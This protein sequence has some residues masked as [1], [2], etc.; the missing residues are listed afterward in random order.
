MGCRCRG[1]KGVR[2]VN[3]TTTTK[4]AAVTTTGGVRFGLQAGGQ[5]R[6]FAT[7]LEANAA[8]VRSGGGEVFRL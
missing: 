6:T 5:L 8:R 1:G 3:T 7:E 2:I 4:G